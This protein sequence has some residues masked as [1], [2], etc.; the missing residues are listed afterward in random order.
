MRGEVVPRVRCDRHASHSTP[1]SALQVK[2]STG[3][4]PALEL[5][6]VDADLAV[7]RPEVRLHLGELVE[8]LLA[9]RAQQLEPASSLPA[10]ARTSA[11]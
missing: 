4:T 6:G 10:P 7:D 1:W 11:A 3:P 9:V 2:R 8:H 5:V